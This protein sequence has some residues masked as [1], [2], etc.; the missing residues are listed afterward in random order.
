MNVE[1]PHL[2]H[3]QV[4]ELWYNDSG[5]PDLVLRCCSGPGDQENLPG[6]L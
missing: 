4:S 5:L 6:L 1:H 3:G 2:E